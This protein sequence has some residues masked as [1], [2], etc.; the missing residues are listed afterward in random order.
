MNTEIT[1]TNDVTSLSNDDSGLS[2]TNSFSTLYD[3]STTVTKN[4]WTD[5]FTNDSFSPSYQSLLQV[6]NKL[7]VSNSVLI[8]AVSNLVA[9][10]GLAGN[11]LNIII[12]YRH[13]TDSSTTNIVLRSL[14]VAD[15]LYLISSPVANITIYL[16]LLDPVM[17]VIAQTYLFCYGLLFSSLFLVSSMTHIVVIA[18]ERVLAVYF[19]LK[20]SCWVTPKRMTVISLCAHV[21]WYPLWLPLFFIAEITWVESNAL[22]RSIPI[23]TFTKF[24][25]NNL[26]TFEW[27]HRYVVLAIVGPVYSTLVL[28]C[29]LAIGVKLYLANRNRLKLASFHNSER[30]VLKSVN[31]KVV[32][33]LVV[34]CVVYLV[35]SLPSTLF[36]VF[37]V[38]NTS[39]MVDDLKRNLQAYG[40]DCRAIPELINIFSEVEDLGS[41]KTGRLGMSVSRDGAR[42]AARR[43]WVCSKTVLGVQRDGARCAA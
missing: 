9:L 14:A 34:V 21:F 25:E 17:S 33:M 19:P 23:P 11:V 38:T 8:A 12:L 40:V 28:I 36:K 39:F 43:C 35:A 37:E 29:C 22:N 26:Q 16:D 6:V 4:D 3:D 42:C 13:R 41:L 31:V 20:V 32:R 15:I 7:S 2:F 5:S 24:Y 18:V 27:F 1:L 30:S 10:L